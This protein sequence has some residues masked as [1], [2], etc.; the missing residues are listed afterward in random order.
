M[1]TLNYL[2]LAAFVA[3]AVR[4][5]F[6]FPKNENT[7]SKITQ[8]TDNEIFSS[9]LCDDIIGFNANVPIKITLDENGKIASVEM[10]DNRET[11]SFAR[12]VEQSG[13]LRKWDGLTLAQA[14]VL[15]V[16][17]VSGAT[18]TSTA[19]IASVR[20]MTSNQVERQK[21]S[22]DTICRQAAVIAIL[23]CALVAFFSPK[24]KLLRKIVL[25]LSILVL[26]FWTSSMLSL[27]VF[28]RW[29]ANGISWQIQIPLV[30]VAV[31]AIL[32]PIFTKRAFYC[33]YLCPFG[34]LQEFSGMIFKKKIKISQKTA[35]A[36]DITRKILI[37]IL[38][39]IIAFGLGLDVDR[40]EPFSA[41]NIATISFGMAVFAI[42]I[43]A[44]S[45]IITRP[46]C[47]FLCPTGLLLSLLQKKN[48][49]N[50]NFSN[51]S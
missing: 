9:P 46:W 39:A 23:I 50:H 34:A 36:I 18:Y 16:D 19:I 47:R 1:K 27:T 5:A 49:K 4:M 31:A 35:K 17:A 21:L 45:L 25:L 43:I 8:H 33:S 30:A 11:P 40:V 32:L 10:L 7:S 44:I 28:F 24:R 37:I 3:A 20:R 12:R 38:F 29:I 48:G 26:G 15:N 51:P 2:I 6:F 22:I 13:L 14:A 42:A 41:F